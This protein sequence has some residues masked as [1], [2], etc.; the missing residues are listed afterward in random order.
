MPLVSAVLLLL[1]S[2]WAAASAKATT[3][4]TIN[5]RRDAIMTGHVDKVP[6]TFAHRVHIFEHDWKPLAFG[7]IMISFLYAGVVMLIPF[8]FRAD[9]SLGLTAM[10]FAVGCYH[11]LSGFF[12]AR[13]GLIERRK[14]RQFLKELEVSAETTM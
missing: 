3:F 10:C 14:I 5:A 4:A 6:I 12:T 1:A 2:I 11:A 13:H 9:E 7:G 8:L